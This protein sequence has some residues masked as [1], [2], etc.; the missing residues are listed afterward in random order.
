MD[1]QY[2][3]LYMFY[4]NLKFFDFD[5]NIF[6]KRKLMGIFD[7]VIQEN[8]DPEEEEEEELEVRHAIFFLAPLML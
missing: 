8:G 5:E 6:L 7:L 4:E 2:V 3:T 1:L